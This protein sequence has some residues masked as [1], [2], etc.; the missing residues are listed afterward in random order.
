M[1]SCYTNLQ[2]ENYNGALPYLRLSLS[3]DGKNFT[4]IF[5]LKDSG[6]N[7]TL[8]SSKTFQKLPNWS[9]THPSI[10]NM[11]PKKSQAAVIGATFEVN[12]KANI[13]LK[14]KEDEHESIFKCIVHISNDLYFPGLLGSDLLTSS[15]KHFET[16]NAICFKSAQTKAVNATEG[17]KLKENPSFFFSPIYYFLAP[18]TLQKID[19]EG[20][21]K[22]RKN[23]TTPTVTCAGGATGGLSEYFPNGSA[24][25]ARTAAVE[26]EPVFPLPRPTGHPTVDTINADEFSSPAERKHNL[27]S[28]EEQ[29]FTQLSVSG[30][31]QRKEKGIPISFEGSSET[32]QTDSQIIDSLKLKNLPTSQAVQIMKLCNEFID[33]FARSKYDVSCTTAVKAHIMLKKDVKICSQ[34]YLPIPFH[35]RDQFQHLIDEFTKKGILSDYTDKEPPKFISNVFCVK[36]ANSSPRFILDSRLLNMYTENTPIVVPSH[37][38]IIAQIEGCDTL[39][40]LDISNAYYQIPITSSSRIFTCFHDTRRTIKCFNTCPQGYK[41]SGYYMGQAMS[42]VFEGMPEVLHFCDDVLIATKAP[43]GVNKFRFHLEAIRRAMQRLRR[44][45]FKIR[46]EKIAFAS[47]DIMFLGIIINVNKIRIPEVRIQAMQDWEPPKTKK[48]VQAMLGA[49]NFYRGFIPHFSLLVLPFHTLTTI[50]K[51]GKFV[52]RR[53]HDEAFAAIKRAFKKAAMRYVPN[54]KWPFEADSDASNY[55]T[56][57]TLN[58]RSED[59]KLYMIATTSRKFT[60]S[61]MAYSAY[62]KEL[63][64]VLHGLNAFNF[65]LQYAEKI[66][67]NVDCSGLLF[68]KI[69]QNSTSL[70]IRFVLTISA[71]NLEMRHK[72]GV[73]HQWAD[74]WSRHIAG[75]EDNSIAIKNANYFTEAEAAAIAHRMRFKPKEIFTIDQMRAFWKA[76]PPMK[77]GKPKKYMSKAVLS[78]AK[79]KPTLVPLKNKKLPGNAYPTRFVTSA[80]MLPAF[81]PQ[82]SD[83]I[84]SM[85]AFFPSLQLIFNE[86]LESRRKIAYDIIEATQSWERTHSIEAILDN[87]LSSAIHETLLRPSWSEKRDVHGQ[88]AVHGGRIQ[89]TRREGQTQR[90]L[91]RTRGERAIDRRGLTESNETVVPS[92][93]ADSALTLYSKRP[94]PPVFTSPCGN[95][96]PGYFTE[97]PRTKSSEICRPD[98]QESSRPSQD[99]HGHHLRHGNRVRHPLHRAPHRNLELHGEIEDRVGHCDEQRDDRGNHQRCEGAFREVQ[100]KGHVDNGCDVK[101]ETLVNECE[102]YPLPF[103]SEQEWHSER[104]AHCS[105]GDGVSRLFASAITRVGRKTRVPARFRESEDALGAAQGD[106]ARTRPQGINEPRA[107][108]VP[109]VLHEREDSGGTETRDPRVRGGSDV[110]EHNLSKHSQ[111][112]NSFPENDDFDCDSSVNS[113]DALGRYDGGDG[114]QHSQGDQALQRRHRDRRRPAELSPARDGNEKTHAGTPEDAATEGENTFHSQSTPSARH[115]SQQDRGAGRKRSLSWPRMKEKNRKPEKNKDNVHIHSD[116]CTKSNTRCGNKNSHEFWPDSID[117]FTTIIRSMEN[118][119]ISIDEFISLQKMDPAFHKGFVAAKGENS[120]FILKN[121]VLIRSCVNGPEKICLPRAALRYLFMIYHWTFEGNHMSS[122]KI[123]HKINAKFFRYNLKQEII[124]LC[125]QCLFCI[126]QVA[127]RRRKPMLSQQINA[128]KPR[129]IIAIDLALGYE[130]SSRGHIGFML[131]ID[132][133]SQFIIFVPIESKEKSHITEKFRAVIL[134]TQ[135]HAYSLILCDN[136][137]AFM[138]NTFQNMLNKFNID[139]RTAPPSSSWANGFAERHISM[140][141]NGIRIFLKQFPAKEFDEAGEYFCL[142]HNSQPTSFGLCK[143]DGSKRYYASPAMLHFAEPE[144][145]KFDLIKASVSKEETH[146]QYYTRTLLNAQRIRNEHAAKK[147]ATQAQL[148]KIANR[149]RKVINFEPGEVVHA[150]EHQMSRGAGGSTKAKYVG[151]FIV[152]GSSNSSALIMLQDLTTGKISKQHA[153]HIVKGPLEADVHTGSWDWTAALDSV[154][155]MPTMPS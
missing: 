123:F 14:F 110:T 22:R 135:N 94:N 145:D 53:E 128:R 95:K 65:Y 32:P 82:N 113:D 105:P 58:Q 48:Q 133:F 39:S 131:A 5:L 81:T 50:E 88:K 26:I 80:V 73:N 152:L 20:P 119:I 78:S 106:N 51:G 70:L 79:I 24:Q 146:W 19:N 69:C 64:S 142:A 108:A 35:I 41:N 16:N 151:P 56:S 122:L 42:I 83:V 147:F 153:H 1:A 134:A 102:F 18:P 27:E 103:Y 109:P 125:R 17:E 155:P 143:E 15:F 92:R 29:G 38:D 68:L 107:A 2:Q 40:S 121:G 3:L 77:E 36:K 31:I 54:P 116:D 91:G 98:R 66:L 45:K 90:L 85:V 4:E 8:L 75:A 13:F 67:L 120:N 76:D 6:S 126:T 10:I 7:T 129:Q 34:K 141:K 100:N 62:K 137:P 63:V 21:E 148:L 138:S 130:R 140:A 43:R 25:S 30:T 61:E 28:L 112:D 44:Y 97:L 59:D 60:K 84:R 104:G 23:V 86:L 47:E 89:R 74:T 12:Q 96:I 124:D 149:H 118:G 93:N 115:A 150:R 9:N 57:F 132:L 49:L 11:A 99:L 72:P 37:Q 117:E 101:K 87:F 127:S 55:C 114:G 33:I 46:A 71:Y 111:E 52:W 136:E 154:L 144:S 139:I